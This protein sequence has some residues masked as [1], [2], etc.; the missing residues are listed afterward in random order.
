MAA[1]QDEIN[2]WFVPSW[3]NYFGVG[4]DMTD[5]LGAGR[6]ISFNILPVSC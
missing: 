4:E 3:N 6:L 1:P 5:M 2:A